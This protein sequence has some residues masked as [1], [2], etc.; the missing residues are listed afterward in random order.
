ML[1][2][3]KKI[4]KKKGVSLMVGYVLLVTLA[5]VMGIIAYN[6]MKTYTPRSATECPDGVSILIKN[7]SCQNNMF[8]LTLKNNGRFNISG[9]LI[10]VGNSTEPVAIR[11]ISRNV[12]SG[13]IF[14]NGIIVYLSTQL[15]PGEEKKS[16]FNLSTL[17]I[18]GI[19]MI[20]IIPARLER[21]KNKERIVICTNSLLKDVLANCNL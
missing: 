9:Y 5:V 19:N 21:Q 4:R 18:D 20:E 8:N 3:I 16:Q 6:W 1:L 14:A 12:T 11:D 17:N 15:K 7:Y 13:E 10:K 2:G